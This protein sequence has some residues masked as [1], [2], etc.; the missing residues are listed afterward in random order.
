M[1]RCC[2][3][4]PVRPCRYIC[5]FYMCASPHYVSDC[6][7]AHV[8]IYIWLHIP[9]TPYVCSVCLFQLKAVG[10][11]LVPFFKTVAIFFILFEAD[12]RLESIFYC[13][14]KCLPVISLMFFVLLHG[15]SL[16]EIY[17]YSRKILIGLMFSCLGDA[18]LVWKNAGYFTHGLAMFAIAQVMYCWAFGLR[19]LA[20]RTGSVCALLGVLVYLFILPGLHG[21]MVYLG[22]AY[23]FLICCMA[24]RAIARVKFLNDQWTWTGLCSS[25]GAV[26]FLISDLVIAVNKF[27]F[28]LPYS[29]QLIMATYYAAQLGIAVSVVDSHV[30]A[31]IVKTGKKVKNHRE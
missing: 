25:G 26:L 15:M 11:K 13:I 7:C 18:F 8:V 5:Y 16:S 9:L 20:L 12:S 27:R 4:T 24:W 29:H 28:E 10:P 2:I 6:L 21:I 30:D 19:P 22:G 14:V 17:A 23:I 31:L 3:F 1:T